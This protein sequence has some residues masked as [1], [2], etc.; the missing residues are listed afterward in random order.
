MAEDEDDPVVQA[1]GFQE[2]EDITLPELEPKELVS[3]TATDDTLA[4]I[5]G[6]VTRKEHGYS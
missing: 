3:V 4:E 1:T 2:G 6:W 5:R